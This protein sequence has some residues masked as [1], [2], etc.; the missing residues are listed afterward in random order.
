MP[1]PIEAGEDVGAGRRFARLPS[2]ARC[3]ER[4]QAGR[5]GEGE[6]LQVARKPRYR[7]VRMRPVF[8]REAPAQFHHNR[9]R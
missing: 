3:S 6:L 4:A 9:R 7:S 2:D 5:S 8:R 1:I